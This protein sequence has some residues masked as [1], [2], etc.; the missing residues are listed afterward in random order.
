MKMEGKGIRPQEVEKERERKRNEFELWQRERTR[1]HTK[2]HISTLS[3]T[4]KK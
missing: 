2:L 4:H 3:K 1:Q